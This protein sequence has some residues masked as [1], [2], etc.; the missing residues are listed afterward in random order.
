[1]RRDHNLQAPCGGAGRTDYRL[2]DATELTIQAQ[3]GPH[4]AIGTG[5]HDMITNREESRGC[6][7]PCSSYSPGCTQQTPHITPQ[8]HPPTDRTRQPRVV[9]TVNN[10]CFNHKALMPLSR[11]VNH[12]RGL[13]AAKIILPIKVP[14]A[15]MSPAHQ[16]HNLPPTL[17][18]P[19]LYHPSAHPALTAIQHR[20]PQ[21]QQTAYTQ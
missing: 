10:I 15:Q 19:R 17:S 1:M 4:R 16:A 14:A 5:A 3:Q 21:I 6:R 12:I 20:L 18:G 13:V 9:N 2:S 11:M 7:G 8:E